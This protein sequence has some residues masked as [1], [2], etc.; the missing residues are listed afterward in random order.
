[1]FETDDT[2]LKSKDNSD[3]RIHKY[4]QNELS[5][6][7]QTKAKNKKA[8]ILNRSLK[9]MIEEDTNDLKENGYFREG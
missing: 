4:D 8:G 9:G 6:R 2:N 7:E 3:V 5:N 1:M